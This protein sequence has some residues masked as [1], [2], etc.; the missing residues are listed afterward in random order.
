M[1]P[2][3]LSFSKDGFSSGASPEPLNP[4]FFNRNAILLAHDLIGMKIV[5]SRGGETASGVISE[6]DAY[7]GKDDLETA[8]YKGISS[9]NVNWNPGSLYVYSVQGHTMLTIAAPPYDE[10]ACV[11]IRE[12]TL[13]SGLKISGPGK[14]SKELG[15]TTTDNGTNFY[16]GDI[17]LQPSP[18]GEINVLNSTRSNAR[19]SPDLKL[20]F[21]LG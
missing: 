7:P 12:I 5:V 8:P 20:R 21:K 11:L 19:K 4:D 18:T 15:I 14:V 10:G 16:Y 3:N 9:K 2:R 17:S 13:S 1:S 6:V